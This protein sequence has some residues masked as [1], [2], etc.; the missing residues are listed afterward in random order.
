M[1]PLSLP[2]LFRYPI[3]WVAFAA[4]LGLSVLGLLTMNSFLGGDPFF[5]RQVAW[6][7]IGVGAFFTAS[8]IDWRFLRGSGVAALV[9]GLLLVPLIILI[10]FGTSTHGAR[11]W[12]DLGALCAAARGVCKNR[13]HYHTCQVFFT[14][15][16][17]DPQREAYFD[18]WRI[19]SCGVHS[20]GASARFWLRYHCRV[21]MAWDGL[22]FRHL[23][24][25]SCDR[26][27]CRTCRFRGA[28]VFWV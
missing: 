12:F 6:V 10:L 28:V 9:Y 21:Y 22:G 2:S 8:L 4:A 24:T 18:F 20:G 23:P 19:C 11:G 5:A 1:P 7:S 15:A 27:V 13:T 25:A 17:R 3:D 26:A 16:Y 14:A